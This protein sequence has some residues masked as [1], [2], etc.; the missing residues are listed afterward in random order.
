MDAID[1]MD[2]EDAGTE[3]RQKLQTPRAIEDFGA[4][5]RRCKLDP[6]RRPAVAK[7]LAAMPAVYQAG[8]LRALGGRSPKAAIKAFCLE[9]VGWQR[10]EVATCTALACPL[11]SYRP[12]RRAVATERRTCPPGLC[13]ARGGTRRGSTLGKTSA[14]GRIGKETG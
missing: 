3:A 5:E 10:A 7:K 2:T 4:P 8:Y 14:A 9:C 12:F 6:T 11:W 1:L 13:A